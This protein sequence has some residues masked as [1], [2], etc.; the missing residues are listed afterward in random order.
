LVGS[1]CLIINGITI[2]KGVLLGVGAVIRKSTKDNVIVA[3]KAAK[4]FPKPVD[5]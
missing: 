1:N 2:D 5:Y 4:Q 3:G